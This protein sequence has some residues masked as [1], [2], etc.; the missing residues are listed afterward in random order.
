MA[1]DSAPLGYADGVSA[2]GAA[3]WSCDPARPAATMQIAAFAGRN[4][5]GVFPASGLRQDTA[6]FCGQ[7]QTGFSFAFDRAARAQLGAGIFLFALGPG[8]APEPLLASNPAAALPHDLPAGSF[9]ALGQSGTISG[10]VAFPIPP[11]IVLYAGAPAEDGG[12]AF[13]PAR[14]TIQPA[15]FGFSLP[16]PAISVPPGA[17]LP[18][19]GTATDAAGMP[20]PFAAPVLAMPGVNTV[21]L[22]A[23]VAQ[24]PGQAG[25]RNTRFTAWLP[26]GQGFAALSG[27]V[28]LQGN[29]GGFSEALLLL[30]TTAD[31]QAACLA[32]NGQ[33]SSGLPALSRLWAGI[34]KNVGA[35]TVSIPVSLALPYPVKLPPAGACAMLA[36]GAGYAYL[37][38]SLPQLTSTDARLVLATVPAKAPAPAVIPL[39]VGGEFRFPVGTAAPLSVY[40]GLQASRPIY[41]DAIAGAFSAAPVVGAPPSSGWLPVPGGTWSVGTDFYVLSAAACAAAHL[42][43]QPSNGIFAILRNGTPAARPVPTGARLVMRLGADSAGGFPVQRSLFQVLTSPVADT[44]LLLNPGDCLLGWE[45]TAPEAGGTPGFLDVEDQSTVYLRPAD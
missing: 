9:A 14:V 17:T 28:S 23:H 45:A 18:L 44:A 41:V 21:P 35:G 10:S 13:G 39:G 25:I 26:P 8:S 15:G 4:L 11:R 12:P 19:F 43:A 6:P 30:G 1:A 32:Q 24:S 33:V 7:A 22:L 29:A 20:V 37:N 16:A 42:R 34:L 5:L 2:A 3:G 40:V 36:I 27:Q 38:G 31:G